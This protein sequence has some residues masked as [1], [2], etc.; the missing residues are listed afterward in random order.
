MS[1]W[2]PLPP[3]YAP[4]LAP[5]PAELLQPVGRELQTL[6][7]EQEDDAEVAELEVG[8]RVAEEAEAVR[9]DAAAERE[10]AEHRRHVQH[11]GER[12]HEHRRRQKD[13]DVAAER[14][15]AD[16]LIGGGDERGG[17]YVQQVD[18]RGRGHVQHAVA[19][20]ARRPERWAKQA[21]TA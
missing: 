8:L 11:A 20:C 17:G 19:A 18:Q 2:P 10:E 14:I 7:E 4:L 5:L 21:S 6:D 12:H 13:E 3:P 16:G 15:Q 1:V 9:A